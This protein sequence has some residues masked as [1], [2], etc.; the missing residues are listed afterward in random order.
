M[1]IERV[2]RNEIGLSFQGFFDPELKDIIKGLS[3]SRYEYDRKVWV[4]PFEKKQAMIEAVKEHC[5]SNNIQLGDTPIFVD[6]II[7][8]SIPFSKVS[9]FAKE[10]KFDYE[11]EWT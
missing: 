1:Q 3:Y 11:K 9:R 8:T 4:L 10:S 7:D 2:S 6:K 5:L